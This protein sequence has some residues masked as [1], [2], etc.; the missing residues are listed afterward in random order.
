MAGEKL[1]YAEMKSWYDAF[2]DVITNYGG[3]I[4]TLTPP[5]QGTKA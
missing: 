1:S 5:A 4:T 2:N 3:E